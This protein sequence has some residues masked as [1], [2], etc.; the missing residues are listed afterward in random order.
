MVF[1]TPPNSIIRKLGLH[2]TQAPGPEE[3][4][5]EKDGSVK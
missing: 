4:I 3:K 5:Q 2:I 1:V